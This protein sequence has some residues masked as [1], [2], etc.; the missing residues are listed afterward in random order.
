MSDCRR[1]ELLG[2]MEKRACVAMGGTGVGGPSWT[3]VH[4]HQVK[5]ND[6]HR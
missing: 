4:L 3:G 6:P 5:V 2:G 1:L